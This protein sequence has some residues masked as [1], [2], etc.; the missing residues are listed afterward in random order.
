MDSG[1]LWRYRQTN[2]VL[3]AYEWKS[4]VSQLRIAWEPGGHRRILFKIDLQAKDMLRRVSV[5]DVDVASIRMGQGI[6][7]VR[8]DS[9]SSPPEEF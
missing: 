7:P 9:I 1:L 2:N 8:I 4:F 5:Y 3:H 6:D